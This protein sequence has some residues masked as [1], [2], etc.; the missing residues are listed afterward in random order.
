MQRYYEIKA[1]RG[2]LRGFFHQVD[3]PKFPVCIIFHGL[4]G[5]K[6]G[7]KFSYT[8][9]SRS[10]VQKG[11]GVLRMDFLGSGDSDLE[12]SEMTFKNELE[13]A[14]LILE[15]VLKMPTTSEVY[16]LG[17]SMGGVIASEISKLYPDLIKKMCLW[18]PAYN[19]PKTIE[20]LTTKVPIS[21]SGY[22]NNGFLVSQQF[23]N[24]IITYDFYRDLNK[25][26][27][28]LLIIHGE[29]DNLVDFNISKQYL[30]AFKRELEFIA[31]KEGSHNFDNIEHIDF[32]MNQTINFLIK[33]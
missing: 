33:G 2:I 15:E 19:L 13:E 27:N 4:T 23:V 7:T 8:R 24:D 9:L 16:L 20:Y 28:E 26:Q 17:H 14:K 21:E 6:T 1:P 22:N 12:F 11:I 31:I 30:V 25:Y 29:K 32:V 10:L 18:A 5:Q 3:A